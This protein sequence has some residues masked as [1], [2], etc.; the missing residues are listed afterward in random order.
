MSYPVPVIPKHYWQQ[1]HIALYL[2]DPDKLLW[3]EI[4]EALREHK[5]IF[6]RRITGIGEPTSLEASR[7]QCLT[8]S[9][10]VSS[11]P[12]LGS[13]LK[14]TVCGQAERTVRETRT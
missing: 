7:Q 1:Q 12:V 8:G 3:T 2:H 14:E 4:P 5:T 11:A 10:P 9:T 13:Y 6:L